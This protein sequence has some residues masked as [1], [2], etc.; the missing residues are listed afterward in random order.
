MASTTFETDVTVIEADWLN[1][2]NT[3]TFSAANKSAAVLLTPALGLKI[4]IESADG[5]LF[6]AIV[7]AAAATYSDDGGSYCGTVFIPTGGDGSTAWVRVYEETVKSVWYGTTT[8]T[9]QNS[10]ATYYINPV[11]SKSQTGP[12]ITETSPYGVTGSTHN[13]MNFGTQADP[14][15]EIGPLVQ[16]D[17]WSGTPLSGAWNQTFTAKHYKVDG[18]SA[19]TAITGYADKI[20]GTNDIVG[21][22][23]RAQARN[24]STDSSCYAGWF[25]ALAGPLSTGSGHITGIE[26][27]TQN[28][29]GDRGHWELGVPFVT[30]TFTT[31]CWCFPGVNQ[32]AGSHVTAAYGMGGGANSQWHTGL[33]VQTDSIVPYDGST[34]RNEGVLIQ[35]G[36]ILAKQ[37][38]GIRIG[39]SLSPTYFNYGIDLTGGIFKDSSAIKL[40]DAHQVQF[41]DNNDANIHNNAQHLVLSTKLASAGN[42]QLSPDGIVDVDTDIHANSFVMNTQQTY[43]L[44][45]TSVV[46]RTLLASASATTLNNNNV[47]AGLIT[48]LWLVGCAGDFSKLL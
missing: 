14:T 34:T 16:I 42:I 4:F 36:S 3:N 26:I 47:L 2:A 29:D 15:E 20:G 30:D 19:C 10:E 17:K 28:V 39:N 31:G 22:H 13:D 21:V 9:E 25:Y 44:T 18:D 46:D 45:A 37:Y 24:T 48:D 27:D 11:T 35:G 1:D 6:K 33:F 41:G 12:V 32:I 40:G 43:T 5:G 23:G 38:G 7:S 8:P